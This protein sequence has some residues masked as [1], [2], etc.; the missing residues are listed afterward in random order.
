MMK[1]KNLYLVFVAIFAITSCSVIDSIVSDPLDDTSWVL[2]AYRGEDL[3]KGSTITA[4]FKDGE[5]R[6]TS[7]CNSYFGSYEINGDNI[8][9]TQVGA[10]LMACLDPEGIMDQEATFH[11]MLTEAES[12]QVV[13]EQLVIL[14]SNGEELNF[15]AQE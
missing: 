3:I 11:S 14:S 10:T 4:I 8:T 15:I 6:G 1:L 13:N 5:V 2:I 9:F 7:G 12:F